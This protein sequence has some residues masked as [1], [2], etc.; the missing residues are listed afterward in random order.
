MAANSPLTEARQDALLGGRLRLRQ[1]ASGHR[2]GTDAILLG[3]CVTASTAGRAADVGA[4][5]GAAGLT[6]LS[7]APALDMTFIEIDAELV[8]LCA[9][10][11]AANAFETRARAAS[12]DVLRPAARRSAGLIDGGFDLV[13]T[14]PPFHDVGAVRS[15]PDP[16]KA[17]A[18]VATAGLEAWMKASLALLAPGGRFLM[19]HRADALPS[20][21]E[22]AKGRLGALRLL[23]VHPRA[24]A[25]AIRLLLSG[26]KGSR[27]PVTLL[28]AL[29]LHGADGA[30]APHAAAVHR[31]EAG[32]EL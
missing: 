12:A 5:A 26:Q 21:V 29:V 15:S 24:D 2:A 4:G 13:L 22:A 18:H 8:A 27:A 32:I 28:P 9:A 10:N 20:I 17:R 23:P 3:A 31:G 16:R 14:N 1:P 7:R 25:P 11:V 6:A 30:F 19:I